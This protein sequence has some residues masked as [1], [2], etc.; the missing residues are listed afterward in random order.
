MS[1]NWYRNGL[2]AVQYSCYLLVTC[3]SSVL[4]TELDMTFI[5]GVF[6]RENFPFI[7]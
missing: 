6:Q 5:D 7:L 2:G 1:N 4:D 3:I